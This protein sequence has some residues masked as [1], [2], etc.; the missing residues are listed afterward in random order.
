MVLILKNLSSF[1][2]YIVSVSKKKLV[3]KISEEHKKLL[4]RLELKLEVD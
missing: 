1:L 4:E 2:L 3:S